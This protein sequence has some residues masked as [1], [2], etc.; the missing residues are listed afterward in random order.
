LSGWRDP[1]PA[2]IILQRVRVLAGMMRERTSFGA[3]VLDH[4]GLTP[5]LAFEEVRRLGTDGSAS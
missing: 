3:Q 1:E 4:C 2:S 5:E